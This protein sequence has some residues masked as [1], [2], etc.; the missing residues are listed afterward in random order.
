MGDFL[1]SPPESLRDLISELATWQTITGAANATAALAFIFIDVEKEP[2]FPFI[3]IDDDEESEGSLGFT[4]TSP[5]NNLRFNGALNML[6]EIGVP[7]GAAQV[8]LASRL[9]YGREQIGPLIVELGQTQGL[10]GALRLDSCLRMWGPRVP[11]KPERRSKNFG[12]YVA[13]HFQ[14]RWS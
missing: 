10:N 1:S 12:E 14:A 8:S 6:I 4:V 2:V 7:A 11:G 3:I 9:K 5:G 13:F